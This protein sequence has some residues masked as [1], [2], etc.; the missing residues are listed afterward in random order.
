MF[1]Q[2][3][4]LCLASSNLQPHNSVC[5][6]EKRVVLCRNGCLIDKTYSIIMGIFSLYLTLYLTMWEAEKTNAFKLN[7]K[8]TR[9]KWDSWS[10]NHNN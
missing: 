9:R 7:G 3:Y 1:H 2:Y 4:M 8:G 5:S 6:T 10:A